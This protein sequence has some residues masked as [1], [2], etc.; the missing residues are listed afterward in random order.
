[1]FL[2]ATILTSLILLIASNI[3]AMSLKSPSDLDQKRKKDDNTM[4][5]VFQK[6][7]GRK[8]DH[9]L[10]RRIKRS[11]KEKYR[12]LKVIVFP[13]RDAR[14][15][16]HYLVLQGKKLKLLRRVCG[17]EKKCIGGRYSGR[18]CNTC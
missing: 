16:K 2:K 7:I 3:D 14:R 5:N 6:T 10:P 15:V 17:C 8:Q 12:V 4:G 1:M 13:C 18:I 11:L 9:Y